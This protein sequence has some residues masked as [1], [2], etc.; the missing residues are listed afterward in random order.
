M[1]T[2]VIVYL[3]D[4][5]DELMT[6]APDDDPNG[7]FECA[8]E[9]WK[10]YCTRRHTRIHQFFYD[11]MNRGWLKKADAEAFCNFLHNAHPWRC[12]R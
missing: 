12:L 7:A 3:V 4:I 10:S 9:W 11:A 8:W 5:R 6:I 1:K 2:N